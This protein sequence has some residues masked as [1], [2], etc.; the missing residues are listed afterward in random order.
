M[1]NNTTKITKAIARTIQVAILIFRVAFGRMG[2]ITIPI[3]SPVAN[4]P[5]SVELVFYSFF[6]FFSYNNFLTNMSKII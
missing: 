4:P 1:A 3:S 6:E 5:F 2:A